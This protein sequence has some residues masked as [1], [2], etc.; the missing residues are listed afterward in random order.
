MTANKFLT[1]IFATLAGLLTLWCL[2]GTAHA[3]TYE[4]TCTR[5]PMLQGRAGE[6]V[7]T[8]ELRRIPTTIVSAGVSS[9]AR[10]LHGKLDKDGTCGGTPAACCDWRTGSKALCQAR[11]PGVTSVVHYGVRAPTYTI[12]YLP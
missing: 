8:C 3:A 10:S 4:E 12:A 7:T 9:K 5:R 2:A 11:R 6:Q 1:A